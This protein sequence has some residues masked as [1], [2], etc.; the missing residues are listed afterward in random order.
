MTKQ[1]AIEHM[2]RLEA[3]GNKVVL[4]LHGTDNYGVAPES[5]VKYL[6]NTAKVVNVKWPKGEVK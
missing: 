2:K 3:K 1:N 4:I 6:P 5:Y